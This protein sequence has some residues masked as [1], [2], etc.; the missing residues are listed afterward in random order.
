MTAPLCRCTHP[1]SDHGHDRSARPTCF[2]SIV[3]GC[4][5]WRSPDVDASVARHPAGKAI[6]TTGDIA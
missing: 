3:C 2:G 4:T 1:R 5:E 6:P